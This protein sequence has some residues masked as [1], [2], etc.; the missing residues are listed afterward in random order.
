MDDYAAKMWG[1]LVASYYLPRLKNTLEAQAN[2]TQFNLKQWEENW[3]KNGDKNVQ[4]PFAHPLKE[5]RQ[6]IKNN[7]WELK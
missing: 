7:P 3:V 4:K 2:N 1:G 6:L 5:A